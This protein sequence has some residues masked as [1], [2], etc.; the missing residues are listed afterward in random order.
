MRSLGNGQTHA[1]VHARRIHVKIYIEVSYQEAKPAPDLTT[2]PSNQRSLL[3]QMTAHPDPLCSACSYFHCS[4]M[5][6]IPQAIQANGLIL[7]GAKS[8]DSTKCLVSKSLQSGRAHLGCEA[9]R[10]VWGV[11]EE[12]VGGDKV[13]VGQAQ[14]VQAGEAGGHLPSHV[15]HLLWVW[16]AD[17]G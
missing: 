1:A 10:G 2:I 4:M 13:A 8:S 16:P 17:A 7:A 14:V 12:H 6:S 5:V 11:A 9:G 3:L 15:Q